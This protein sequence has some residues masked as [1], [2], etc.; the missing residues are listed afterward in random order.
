MVIEYVHNFAHSNISNLFVYQIETNK[1]NKMLQKTRK[2][3][4]FINNNFT[5][6]L[7]SF[8]FNKIYIN[9]SLLPASQPAERDFR[10][11]RRYIPLSFNVIM[12]IPIVYNLWFLI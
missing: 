2:L 9:L 6:N 1:Y 7:I 4:G 5:F 11:C 12:Y 8:I 10:S 3:T